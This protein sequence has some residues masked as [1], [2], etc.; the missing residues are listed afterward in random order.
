[1]HNNNLVEESRFISI[2]H[3]L[4]INYCL[5]KILII[6]KKQQFAHAHTVLH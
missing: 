1:M 3:V 6:A 4:A 5:A 2:V